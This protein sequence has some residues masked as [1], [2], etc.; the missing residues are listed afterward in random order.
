M[1]PEIMA[2]LSDEEMMGY[3]APQEAPKSSGM[4]DEEMM[5]AGAPTAEKPSAEEQGEKEGWRG[6]V[7]AGLVGARNMLNPWAADMAAFPSQK[8]ECQ[9]ASP[10][11]LRS[12]P[13]LLPLPHPQDTCRTGSVPVI[14]RVRP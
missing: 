7:A 3:G 4:S 1:G 14:V 13:Q 6:D 2:G 5:S 9:Y 11:V 12:M 8:L 10:C